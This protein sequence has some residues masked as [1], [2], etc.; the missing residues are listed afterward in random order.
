MKE[1]VLAISMVM[2]LVLLSGCSKGYEMRKTAGEYTVAV[3]LDK[4]SPA[5]GNNPMTIAIADQTGK[6]V[7]DAKVTVDYSMPAM[8]GMPAMNYSTDASPKGTEYAATVN[9]SMAGAWNIA[10]KI[11][12]ADKTSTVN[13]NV[14]VS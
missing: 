3:K 12:R 4:S 11:T 2:V 6:A 10:V 7:T 13:L 8:P 14:D 1:K 9:F 5:M